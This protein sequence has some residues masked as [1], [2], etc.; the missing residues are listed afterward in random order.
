[1]SAMIPGTRQVAKIGI[2]ALTAHE[3]ISNGEIPRGVTHRGRTWVRT[4]VLAASLEAAQY[5]TAFRHDRSNR[6]TAAA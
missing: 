3:A 5:R 2:T 6:M 1:M 4:R